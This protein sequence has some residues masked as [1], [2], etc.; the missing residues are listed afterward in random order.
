M[1]STWS[2]TAQ[3]EWSD[4]A[5]A[6]RTKELEKKYQDALDLNRKEHEEAQQEVVENKDAHL[7]C[8]E[9]YLDLLHLSNGKSMD[10]QEPTN[11][12]KLLRKCG[13]KFK[14]PL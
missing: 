14:H 9:H 11:H 3:L 8:W 5:K 7:T 10:N 13:F 6:K 2:P 1:W 4:A 12:T